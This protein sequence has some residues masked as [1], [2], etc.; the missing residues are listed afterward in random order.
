[1]QITP[2]MQRAR[3][4][5][6]VVPVLAMFAPVVMHFLFT[7]HRWKEAEVVQSIVDMCTDAGHEVR[8][9]TTPAMAV[10][11]VPLLHAH[12]LDL[13]ELRLHELHSVVDKACR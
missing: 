2:A 3:F 7:S 4:I 13:L 9:R 12:Q 5:W 6:L 1:M 11:V 10:E 8:P